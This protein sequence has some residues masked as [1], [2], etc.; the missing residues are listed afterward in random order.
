MGLLEQQNLLARLYT[1]ADLRGAF[2]ENPDSAAS[3][4]GLTRE[5]AASV[6]AILPGEVLFFS[7]SLVHK[8]LR[9]VEKLLPLCRKFLGDDFARL[10]DEFSSGHNPTSTKKHLDDAL[11]FTDW[12][13]K[14]EISP[15]TRDAAR[16][17]STRHRFFIS[18]R[19]LSYCLLAHDFRHGRM[20]KPRKTIAIWC[21]FRSRVYSYFI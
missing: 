14:K 11:A 12:L 8:R 21:R 3:E 13:L 9:E 4:F 7:R 17:E 5:E 15:L 2:L 20:T 18:N 1:D 10:F 6:A 16:L 19:S